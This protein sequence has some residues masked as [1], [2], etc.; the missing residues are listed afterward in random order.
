[1]P[2]RR[3][4]GEMTAHSE[5]R[6]VEGI[7]LDAMPRGLFRVHLD[8]GRRIIASLGAAT[9]RV[10]IRVVPGDRVAV[11]LSAYDPSRGSIKS[12]IG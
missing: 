4:P 12:R 1:M 9:R 11:E 5:H 10:T 2:G 7:I 8:D 6:A 3:D